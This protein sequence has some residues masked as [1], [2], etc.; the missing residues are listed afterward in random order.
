MYALD[1]ALA[2]LWRELL[3]GVAQHADVPLRWVDHGAP[4]PLAELWQ[5][6]DLG[7]AFICGYP[8]ATWSHDMPRPLPLAAPLPRGEPRPQYASDI[9]VRTD[10]PFTCIDDLFGSRI[11]WTVEDSQ[12]GYQALR[13]WLAPQAQAQGG[14][15]FGTLVGPLVTP[16][17]VVEAV[18][19]GQADGGPLDTYAHALWRRHEPAL[20]AGLRVVARTPPTAMPLFAAAASMPEPERERLRA[21]LLGCSER[22]DLAP[23]LDALCL[24]GFGPVDPREYARLGERARVADR[25][26]YPALR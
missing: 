8:W 22:A 1:A 7:C 6:E 3:L 20:V 14:A 18:L 26:G 9:V 4:A 24:D 12:S 21:G 11:A 13:T 10:S 16:R 19:S 25:L 15:L 17:K 23:L 2:A 5:R